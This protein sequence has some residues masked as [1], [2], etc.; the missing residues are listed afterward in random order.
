M[1]Q[2]NFPGLSRKPQSAAAGVVVNVNNLKET[3]ETIRMLE[4][5]LVEPSTRHSVKELSALLDDDFT[6][7]GRSGNVYDKWVVIGRIQKEETS[8]MTLSDFK[9]V[10]LA[11]NVILATYRATKTETGGQKSY[12]LRSSIWR[13]AGDK[14]Q[15]FFHQGTTASAK[16]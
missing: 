16:P 2:G 3:I 10:G 9:I 11:P 5:K 4:E 15:M 12:S 14:W 8:R 7:F 6:E 13:R 1:V